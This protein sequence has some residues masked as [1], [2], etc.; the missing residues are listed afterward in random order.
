MVCDRVLSICQGKVLPNHQTIQETLRK[1][2]GTLQ[3]HQD[4][5]LPLLHPQ[6]PRPVPHCPP[7]IPHISTRTGRTGPIPPMT[8]TNPPTSRNRWTA[9]VRNQRWRSVVA[10]YRL[11]LYSKEDD[12]I[13]IGT[14]T[15]LENKRTV[16]FCP[17]ICLV[18]LAFTKVISVL[19][20]VSSNVWL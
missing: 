20:T 4:T 15:L 7:H 1:E 11:Y 8:T 2:L 12:K 9:R 14:T 10:R 18:W 19:V 13:D 5:R 17:S 16:K 6:T 3:S